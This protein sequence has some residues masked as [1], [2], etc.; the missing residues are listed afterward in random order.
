MTNS[1][2]KSL[3]IHIPFCSSICSYCDFYKMIANDKTKEKYIEYLIKE[4]QIKQ[5]NLKNLET[6]YIGGGTPS[7]LNLNLLEKFLNKLSQTANLN[8]LKEFSFEANP[9]DINDELLKLLKHFN[10]NRISLGI[11]S[12]NHNKLKLLNRNHDLSTI[13][14]SINLLNEYGFSINVDYMFGFPG[15]TIHTVKEELDVITNFNINHI[16]CYSLILEDKTILYHKYLKGEFEELDDDRETEIYYFICDYLKSKG[17]IHYEISNFCKP[18]HQSYHNLR[19][20]DNEEYEAIGANASNYVGNIRATNINNLNK[21]F[22]SIDNNKLDYLEYNVLGEEDIIE[23]EIMLGFRKTNGINLKMFFEKFNVDLFDRYPVAKT[24]LE[25]GLLMQDGEY[26][27]I[28]PDKLY[29]SNEIILKF[30]K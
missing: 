10:V 16:S 21:Y 27:F 6:I 4:L 23:N 20:W 24:L 19:Y 17:Y 14:K 3:Y 13:I 30:L 29:I 9:N 7:S 22:L 28:A 11:Q 18:N 8:I 15:E 2:I 5:N 1:L 12:V 25:K 26:I